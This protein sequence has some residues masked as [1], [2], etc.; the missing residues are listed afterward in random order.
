MTT[1]GGS[2]ILFHLGMRLNSQ[3]TVS[4]KSHCVA[5]VKVPQN[6]VQTED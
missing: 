4:R 2:L 1:F 3:L 5:D 6:W